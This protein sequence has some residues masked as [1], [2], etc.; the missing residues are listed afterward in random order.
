MRDISSPP[1]TAPILSILTASYNQ[2]EFLEQTIRSVLRQSGDFYLDYVVADGGSSDGSVEII[3]R[4][5]GLLA[6]SCELV[7]LG[8]L[9]YYRS[10]A[11]NFPWCRCRG[12]SYR[13]RSGPDGGQIQALRAAFPQTVGTLVAWLNSDDYYLGDE[14]LARVLAR[15]LAEPDAAIVTGDCSIVDREGRE[16]WKHAVGRVNLRELVHL[17]YHLPQSSTFVRR[18][19]LLR[20]DLDPARKCTFDTDFFIAVLS[21]G[22]RLVKLDD[23]L[24]AFRL[25]GDNI[26]SDPTLQSRI[27][28][29]KM[30]ILRRR[31]DHRLHA[32]L[33]RL[34]QYWTYVL[35]PRADRH[36]RLGP[37][38]ERARA[39]YRELCYRV[40]LGEGYAARYVRGG[41]A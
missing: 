35:K 22:H 11:P 40:I 9:G 29:E 30:T 18:D 20:Y 10:V 34:Y 5:E 23:E 39:R 21:D 12:V 19:V 13:W 31:S 32:A 28:R 17:D 41:A 36:R 7:R 25:Y 24:S 3:R 38:M 37:W 26:T 15:H 2:G 14:A 4:Y 27:F 1:P 8:E 6:A 33:S 16:L